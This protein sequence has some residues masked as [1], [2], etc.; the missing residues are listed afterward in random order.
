MLAQHRVGQVMAKR[1][2]IGGC[3]VLNAVVERTARNVNHA[4][5][6]VHQVVSD[7]VHPVG[8]TGAAGASGV[9]EIAGK[10]DHTLVCCLFDKRPAVTGVTCSA[11]VRGEGVYRIESRLMSRMA[12]YTVVCW[13]LLIAG[14]C[15]GQEEKNGAET[16]RERK[17]VFDIPID[18]ESRCKKRG[19]T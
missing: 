7:T 16:K 2:Q 15:F 17:R 6:G 18:D 19:I 3:F 9:V 13:R 8:V 4:V 5:S 14:C 12:D 11:M 1:L 10:R